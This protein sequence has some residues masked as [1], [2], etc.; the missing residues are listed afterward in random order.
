[1]EKDQQIES[2]IKEL[3]AVLSH[4]DSKDSDAILEALDATTKKINVLAWTLP[5]GLD[6]IDRDD[7]FITID[8]TLKSHN[9]EVDL[10]EL[11]RLANGEKMKINRKRFLSFATFYAPN[12]AHSKSVAKITTLLFR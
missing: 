2:L 11:L 10:D 4:V 8:E 7:I 6:T 3:S 5:D 9:I 12:S 1:M